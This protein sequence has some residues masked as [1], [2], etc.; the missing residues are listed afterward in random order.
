M[1]DPPVGVLN[2]IVTREDV[3]DALTWRLWHGE[4]SRWARL[5]CIFCLALA[6]LLIVVDIASG[7]YVSLI[8]A[9]ILL[10]LV[11]MI[12]SMPRLAARRVMK[13]NPDL[14]KENELLVRPGGLDSSAEKLAWSDFSAIRESRSSFLLRYAGRRVDLIIPKRAFRDAQDARRF[15]DYVREQ[16]G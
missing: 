1:I 9:A 14:T 3:R 12:A 8:F 15:R 10:L 2:W 13:Q 16:V 5:V 6:V 4:G 7:R 11:A